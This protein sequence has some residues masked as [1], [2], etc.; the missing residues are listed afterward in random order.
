MNSFDIAV[1]A[2]LAIAA[3]TGCNDVIGGA[4]P[5]MHFG[6]ARWLIRAAEVG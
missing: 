3:I 4:C 1:Y 5:A 2:G 6:A